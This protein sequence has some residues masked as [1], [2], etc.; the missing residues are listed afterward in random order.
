MSE[1]QQEQQ[2]EKPPKKGRS[3]L[4]NIPDKTYMDMLIKIRHEN[5]GFQIKP[6]WIC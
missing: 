1:Q 4:L 3:I 6:I 2:A 5:L